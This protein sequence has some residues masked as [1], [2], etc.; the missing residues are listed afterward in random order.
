M[1]GNLLCLV[2]YNLRQTFLCKLV[3]LLCG[4]S[5]LNSPTKLHLTQL[6]GNKATVTVVTNVVTNN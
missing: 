5:L 3:S 1:R 4:Q 2:L 6:Q